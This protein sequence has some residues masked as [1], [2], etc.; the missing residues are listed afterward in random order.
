MIANVLNIHGN[1][2]GIWN[3][4]LPFFAE[5]LSAMHKTIE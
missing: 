1:F 4:K 2:T 5:I 3:L